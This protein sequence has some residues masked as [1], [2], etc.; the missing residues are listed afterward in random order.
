MPA[1]Y[2]RMHF[3]SFPGKGKQQAIQ[4]LYLGVNR[5]I[6]KATALGNTCYMYRHRLAA[7]LQNFPPQPDITND[8]LV[9]AFQGKFT[10]CAVTYQENWVETGHGPELKKG[11][12]IDWS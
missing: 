5:D 4:Q 1:V 12:M 8:D 10:H 9:R 3:L 6:C 2:S 7:T 11:I